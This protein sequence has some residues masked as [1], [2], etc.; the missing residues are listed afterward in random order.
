M[1][2]FKTTLPC[3]PPAAIVADGA[4]LARAPARLIAAGFG[5]MAAKL[6]A[7]V[8]WAIADAVGAEAVDSAS[9][10]MVR[11]LA[12][13]IFG[14]AAAIGS[15][16]PGSALELF[17][18]LAASGSAM[19]LYGDSRPAS[20]AEHLVSH[21]LDM[22]E[23]WQAR[24]GAPHGFQTGLSAVPMAAVQRTAMEPGFGAAAPGNS[25]WPTAAELKAARLAA[26]DAATPDGEAKRKAREAVLAK[27]PDDA[28]LDARRKAFVAWRGSAAAAEAR[29]I[30]PARIRAALAA[31][32][33]PD[34]GTE[35]G[36][37]EAIFR[38]AVAAA[39][40]IRTRYTVLDLA[41]EL[42]MER[43]AGDIAAAAIYGV[44]AV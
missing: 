5:D 25:R 4:M 32:G 21:A 35:L 2:G 41:W 11:P 16:E 23:G 10:A 3:P 9:R 12:L 30:D 39:A 43:E 36:L 42:G 19:A 17:K 28:M 24:G 31:A 14:M 38:R 33:C 37:D 40:L 15:R 18:G 44:N 8:D 22:D 20:G 26:L 6:C 34:T 13:R 1:A 7:D 27:S 29:S